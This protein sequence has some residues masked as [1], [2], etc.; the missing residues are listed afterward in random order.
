MAV[1]INRH[2]LITLPLTTQT[3]VSGLT[4]TSQWINIVSRDE[5]FAG[6]MTL[7]PSG[8]GPAVVILQEI[9]SVNAH[10]RA[11]GTVRGRRLRRPCT[12]YVLAHAP[13]YGN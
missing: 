1:R 2:E 10:I 4:T 5:F 11:G 12:R 8:K 9:L 6:Y 3:G 13:A 7:P